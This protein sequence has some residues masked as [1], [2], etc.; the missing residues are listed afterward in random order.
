MRRPVVLPVLALM[1]A[2][3]FGCG[4]PSSPPADQGSSA[5]DPAATKVDDAVEILKAIE[6][7]RSVGP[8]AGGVNTNVAQVGSHRLK[9]TMDVSVST[10]MQDERAVLGFGGR[11]LAVEF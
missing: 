3:L 2:P 6:A 9:S 11:K 5:S 8:A 4:R 1:T 7:A 10:A